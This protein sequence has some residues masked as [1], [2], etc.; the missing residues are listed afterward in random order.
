MGKFFLVIAILKS[1]TVL[2]SSS[3]CAVAMYRF[4]QTHEKSIEALAVTV[5]KGTQGRL[6]FRGE[7]K[8]NIEE[9]ANMNQVIRACILTH[10]LPE[11]MFKILKGTKAPTVFCDNINPRTLGMVCQ[12]YSVYD[13]ELKKVWSPPMFLFKVQ[14]DGKLVEVD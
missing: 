4:N 8:A 14:K 11:R 6:A 12:K 1:H 5:K 10:A 7:G 9:K 2:A 3:E 13:G